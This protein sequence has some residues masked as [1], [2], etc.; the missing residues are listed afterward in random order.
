MRV[1]ALCG[2]FEVY[3]ADVSVVIDDRGDRRLSG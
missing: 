3:S 2:F 1:V